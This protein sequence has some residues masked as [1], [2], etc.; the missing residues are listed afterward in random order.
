VIEHLEGEPNCRDL[1]GTPAVDGALRE[2]HLLRSGALDELTDDDVARLAEV[3]PLMVF[4]LRSTREV[5]DADPDRL[6]SDAEWIHRPIDEADFVRDLVMDRIADRNLD[7]PDED[8][9]IRAYRRIAATT[10]TLSSIVGQVVDDDR[11]VLFHCTH[12]KDRT[13]VLAAL[14]LA[15]C[16]VDWAVIEADYLRSNQRNAAHTAASMQMIRSMAPP[17]DPAALDWMRPFFA[18]EDRYLAAA[19]DEWDRQWGSFDGFV[20]DGLGIDPKQRAT[21]RTR[22]IG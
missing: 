18:V 14:L 16:G 12:G 22:L 6:P 13:G 7:P 11:A 17:D 19:R 9:M 2:R 10:D 4:D 1:G 8:L 5:D 20:V 15:M 21:L 3:G